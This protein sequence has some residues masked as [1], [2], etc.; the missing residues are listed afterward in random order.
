[1]YIWLLNVY[2]VIECI[3][4]YWMY[5]WLLKKMVIDCICFLEF[6]IITIKIEYKN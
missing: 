5:I 3:Y 1:M 4:G 2:M 6:F